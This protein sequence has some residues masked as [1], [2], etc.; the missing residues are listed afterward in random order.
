[1]ISAFWDSQKLLATIKNNKVKYVDLKSTYLKNRVSFNLIHLE[2]SLNLSIKSGWVFLSDE[3][4]SLTDSGNTIAEL[5]PKDNRPSVKAA[6]YQLMDYITVEKPYW[7][8]HLIKGRRES[9]PFMDPEIVDV[10]EQLHLYNSDGKTPD[11]E[12]IEWWDKISATI[13]TSGQYDRIKIGRLGEY[14]SYQYET[15]RTGREPQWTALDSN[16]AGY[17]LLSQNSKVNSTQLCIEVKTCTTRPQSFFFSKNEWA[18]ATTKKSNEYIIHFWDITDKKKPLLYIFPRS[19]LSKEAPKN[20]G[21]AE[22]INCKIELSRISKAYIPP[23][24]KKTDF[25]DE[26]IDRICS[27]K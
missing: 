27:Y 15:L 25:S 2:K 26:I 8:Y 5:L 1:M 12:T 23:P 20:V 6:R 3:E 11:N 4:L 9:I 17:D 7:S 16:K 19:L 13:Y 18:V 24:M 21:A 22:W 14:C 10:F